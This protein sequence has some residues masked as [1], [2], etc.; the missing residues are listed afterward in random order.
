[1]TPIV[2]EEDEKGI[3][4]VDSVIENVCGG[5]FSIFFALFA[6]GV[7]TSILVMGI[8]PFLLGGGIYHFTQLT[9][10]GMLLFIIVSLGFL[11]GMLASTLLGGVFLYAGL[12]GLLVREVI[13][14]DKRLLSVVIMEESPIKYLE[15]IKKIPFSD[16]KTVE[17]TYNTNCEKCSYDSPSVSIWS[18]NGSWNVSIIPID[19]DSVQ[20][21][22][23]NHK[24]K[25]EKIAGKIC[26]ITDE[27]ATHRTKYTPPIY[28]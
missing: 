1:M 2:K 9:P 25:A 21:Y 18:D 23:G 13:I 4:L 16:L 12:H 15:S 22:H 11:Y 14:I 24:S 19:G 10:F 17:L 8:I 6:L 27:T 20:I 7:A 5:L 28:C 26:R 3:V